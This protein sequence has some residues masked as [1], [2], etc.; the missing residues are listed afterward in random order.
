MA[1]RLSLSQEVARDG[2][3]PPPKLPSITLLAERLQ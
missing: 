1:V 3:V 2:V